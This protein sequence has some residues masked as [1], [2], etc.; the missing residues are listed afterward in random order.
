VHA[1]LTHS[2]DAQYEAA[3][4]SLGFDEH[5]RRTATADSNIATL[6]NR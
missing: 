5:G 2:H 3:L 1:L 4:R 6:I